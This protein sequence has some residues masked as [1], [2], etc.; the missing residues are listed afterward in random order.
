M[1]GL[2]PT[3]TRPTPDLPNVLYSKGRLA[4]DLRGFRILVS[5]LKKTVSRDENEL[6]RVG[7]VW[8]TYFYIDEK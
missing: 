4:S 8:Y 5:N 2:Q 6:C 7:M 3:F 1:V